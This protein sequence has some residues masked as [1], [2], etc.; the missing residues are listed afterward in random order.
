MQAP[1]CKQ[2]GHKKRPKGGQ[3]IVYEDGYFH[4]YFI[5]LNFW[6]DISLFVQAIPRF[7]YMVME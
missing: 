7:P 3:P 2:I 4:S 1:L 5:Q 6:K